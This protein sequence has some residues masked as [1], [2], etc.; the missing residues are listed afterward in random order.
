MRSQ[1]DHVM[2]IDHYFYTSILLEDTPIQKKFL[3]LAQS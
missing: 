3:A 1:D 2:F